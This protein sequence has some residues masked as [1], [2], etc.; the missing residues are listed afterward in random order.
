MARAPEKQANIGEQ[1]NRQQECKNV[2]I[3]HGRASRTFLTGSFFKKERTSPISRFLKQKVRDPDPA[4]CAAS[5][6]KPDWR[7]HGF[8]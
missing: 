2:G 3:L 6:G 4:R 5:T 7:C 8:R 1:R